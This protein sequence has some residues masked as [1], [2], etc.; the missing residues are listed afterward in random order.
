MIFNVNSKAGFSQ[1]LL[2]TRKLGLLLNVAI[3]LTVTL[4]S[5]NAFAEKLKL[6]VFPVNDT[7][8][9]KKHQRDYLY[10]V[11]RE[12]ASA[13]AGS[14]I[15]LI[16]Q[17]KIKSVVKKNKGVCDEDCA[18]KSAATMNARV[19]LVVE[20]H[21]HGSQ[22]LGVV[23]LLDTKDNV[24]LTVKRFF[25]DTLQGA[26]QE[27]QG[28]VM[29]VLSAQFLPLQEEERRALQA[30]QQNI[31]V[32]YARPDQETS[33]LQTS[34]STPVTPPA[35]QSPGDQAASEYSYSNTDIS[36]PSE[37][38]NPRVYLVTSIVTGVIGLGLLTT[39]AV[40]GGQAA[41]EQQKWN[42]E[43]GLRDEL[44]IDYESVGSGSPL[45]MEEAAFNMKY[46]Q[47]YADPTFD[48]DNDL[49]IQSAL[50]THSGNLDIINDSIKA[51]AIVAAITGG[52]GIP[53]TIVSV[54][55]L[56]KY[57]RANKTQTAMNIRVTPVVSP[58]LRGVFLTGTF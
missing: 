20:M 34:P 15:A 17:Q 43:K 55:F 38:T 8:G 48:Y 33:P 29:F 26:E 36:Q 41:S 39:S 12:A 32:N 7:M 44:L 28:A 21:E 46:Q 2:R 11:I 27:L 18:L 56:V 9:L 47:R 30:E 19:A 25:S 52:L 35:N 45:A 40:F 4:H 42:N 14:Y 6:A 13:S 10:D 54:V 49:Q 31:L 57:L 24:L 58:E 37:P 53:A 5:H 3:L 50:D 22:V 16:H 51:N 23:K 1:F